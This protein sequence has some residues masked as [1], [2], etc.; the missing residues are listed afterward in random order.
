MPCFTVPTVKEAINAVIARQ[1]DCLKNAIT[2]VIENSLVKKGLGPAQTKQLIHCKNSKERIE[3][4]QEHCGL[5]F[6]KDFPSLFS[7][8]IG[9]YKETKK[10]VNQKGET[11]Y[12]N[13][14]VLNFDLP[15][16]AEDCSLIENA[17]N[18]VTNQ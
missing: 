3:L 18:N 2:C 14:W 7:K 10:L 13:K 6:W 1:Q 17:Y 4:L 12:R 5:D 16:F 15:K 8:G 9:A 11:F